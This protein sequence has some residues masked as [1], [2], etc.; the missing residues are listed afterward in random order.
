[1]LHGRRAKTMLRSDSTTKDIS[2]SRAPKQRSCQYLTALIAT[3]KR[4]QNRRQCRRRRDGRLVARFLSEGSCAA[5]WLTPTP[6]PA[7]PTR[8]LLRRGVSH[9]P[10]S[11]LL[12][13]IADFCAQSYMVS[14]SFLGFLC[15]KLAWRP[16]TSMP[17]SSHRTAC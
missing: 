16:L 14:K 8:L 15:L 10:F 13:L 12:R 17:R 11:E 2:Q 5:T 1:M 3:L 7:P 6:P 9:C 4:F